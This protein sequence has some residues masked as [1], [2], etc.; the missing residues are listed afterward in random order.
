MSSV[1]A[2]TLRAV[3]ALLLGI[4][5]VCFTQSAWACPSCAT[6]GSG[7]SLIPLILGA[8]VLTPYVVTTVVLRVVR[9]AEAERAAEEQ[10]A[11]GVQ[12]GDG[13]RG[14]PKSSAGPTPAR[15]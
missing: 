7:G 15:V 5:A 2:R 9:K 6:R 1:L 4:A 11:Y 8:M 3:S 13:A 12:A 10:S 14:A